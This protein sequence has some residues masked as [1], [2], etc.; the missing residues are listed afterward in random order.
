MSC[1]CSIIIFMKKQDNRNHPSA[2]GQFNTTGGYKAQIA[3]AVLIGQTLG[4]S[5]YY[6]HEKFPQIVAIPPMPVSFDYDLLGHAGVLSS[7]EQN[8][9]LELEEEN[10]DRSCRSMTN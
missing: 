3:I 10:I 5:A 7:L 2:P 6:K 9:I 8:D 4:V 1:R